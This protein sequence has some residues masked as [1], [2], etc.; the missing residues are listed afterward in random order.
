MRKIQKMRILREVMREQGK[1]QELRAKRK[2][3][4]EQG[5]DNIRE[6]LYNT[7]KHL[8]PE[9]PETPEA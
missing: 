5:V 1:I 6:E 9:T 2:E 3:L 8:L 7:F 4:R